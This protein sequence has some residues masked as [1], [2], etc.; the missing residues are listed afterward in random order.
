MAIPAVRHKF[1]DKETN[2]PT[3]EFMDVESTDILNNLALEIGEIEFQLQEMVLTNVQLPEIEIP[4]LDVPEDLKLDDSMIRQAKDAFSSLKDFSKLS[5]KDLDKSI[6]DL[7]PNTQLQSAFSAFSAKCKTNGMKKGVNLG[8]PY[9]PS[10]NC[11]SGNRLGKSGGCSTSSFS[12]ILNKLTGGAYASGFS[13][14]NK[15]LNN[16]VNLTNF[17]Y[18]MN[19]C[20]VFSALTANLPSN[21]TGI[22]ALG[23]NP[24]SRAAA[25]VL[26]SLNGSKNIL[27]TFDLAS[28][29]AGLHVVKEL[30]GAVKGIV[31]NFSLPK[32]IKQTHYASFSDRLTGSFELFDGKW[33]QSQHDG[34]LSIAKM[35]TN[36]NDLEKVFKGKL[37]KNTF[38]E[39]DLSSPSNGSLD[40]VATAYK[41]AD[42][43]SKN[44]RAL[45]G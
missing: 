25:S 20:G 42:K 7:I 44:L 22:Q 10:L 9:N 5:S 37:M 36:H 23:N 16:L 21:L 28:A 6:A 3:I 27:S 40:K 17:G 29:S 26:G 14:V 38:S 19:M 41:V 1:L 34:S 8:K 12:N 24:L 31:D 4:D 30:P 2:V 39:N 33:N 15:L 18:S 32:E 11:G 45:A 43:F 13:D 35:A